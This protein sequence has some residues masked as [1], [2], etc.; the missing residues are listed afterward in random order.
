MSKAVIQSNLD[1]DTLSKTLEKGDFEEYPERFIEDGIHDFPNEEESVEL[2]VNVVNEM[3]DSSGSTDEDEVARDNGEEVAYKSKI[4]KKISY[5]SEGESKDELSKEDIKNIKKLKKKKAKKGFTVE[6]MIAR[7]FQ[8]LLC[9]QKEF[10]RNEVGNLQRTKKTWYK[11]FSNSFSFGFSLTNSLIGAGILSLSQTCY[12]MGVIGFVAWC[13]AT[14][15]YFVITWNYFNRAIYITGAATMGEL[16]SL[17]FG[18]VFA[19]IVDICNTLFY[20]CVLMVYQ[21]IATQYL[22]GIIQDLTN[23]DKWNYTMDSCYGSKTAGVFCKWHYIILYLVAVCLN[24]PLIIPKSV[25][26]LNRISTLTVVAAVITTFVV[27]GKAIYAG[28]SGKSSNGG[29]ANYPTF[30]G[31]LWPTGAMDF[32]T[33]APFIT[34]NFQIHSCLPPLYVGTKGLS[35]KT[36]LV[37]LQG[38]SY[39][40]VLTCSS[41]F[42]IMAVSG[43]V[44]FDKVSS[45]VLNDF[46]NPDSSDVDWLIIVCRML[47][48]IV[49]V[50][51][52]PAL[53]FPTCAGILRYIPKKWKIVQL[54]NGRVIIL[55]IRTTILILTTFCATFIIDI[56]VVFSVASAIFSIFVVYVG[57]MCIMMLWPRIEKFGDPNFRKLS[58]I[59]NIIYN[60]VVEGNQRFTQND[61]ETA[62]GKEEAEKNEG[63]ADVVVTIDTNTNGQQEIELNEIKE[64]KETNIETSKDDSSSVT[65]YDIDA[66]IMKN[67]NKWIKLPDAYIP[68][69]RYIVYGIAMLICIGLCILSVVGTLIEQFTD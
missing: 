36:K 18:K 51:S 6:D 41:L 34:A 32:F 30:S 40:S 39:V 25:K 26:F 15:V 62:L 28:A 2:D 48:I 24:F 19:C 57:P 22:F 17:I 69:W 58:I 13:L 27:L 1:N 60:K 31:K 59:D 29:D 46:S 44:S 55:M 8:E 47:M 65:T 23:R 35:K 21:V 14:I 16:L 53:M 66:E 7:N 56:G 9:E 43:H 3:D 37:A 61:I 42:I 10:K 5:N 12:K 49:V 20:F 52:Y 63:V 64:Q 11:I 68:I 50:I 33:M 67:K 4:S 54:W 45:N 38:G